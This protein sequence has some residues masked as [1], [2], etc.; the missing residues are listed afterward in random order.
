[1]Q[2]AGKPALVCRPLEPFARHLFTTRAWILGAA[3]DGDSREG[4][5][6]VAASIGATVETL[7]R[8]HQVH[9]SNVAVARA[10]A[11]PDADI[12]VSRESG[13]VVAIQTADCVPLVFVDSRTGAV[14]AAHAGW[15]GLA[16][17]VPA[18]TVAALARRFGTRPADLI[19]A[20]GPSIGA[21]CYEVGEDVKAAFERAGASSDEIARWFFRE[22]RPTPVNRS[23][24]KVP[25]APRAHHYYFD[26]WRATRDQLEQ[27]GVAS[28]RLHMPD[29]CTASHPDVFCS[30]RRDGA[31]AGRMAAV[32]RVGQPAVG[33]EVDL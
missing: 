22:S 20:A 29:L 15:R 17:R 28:D 27:S 16:E 3:R 32:I 8:A 1:V 24:E 33:R 7:A 11:R 30:Y 6:E 31:P 12:I 4:W 25:R 19:V 5:E 2:A 14:A 26:G 18:V 13:M 10:D 23:I 21:C 9:G